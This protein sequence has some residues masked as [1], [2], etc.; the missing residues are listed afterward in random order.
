MSCPY[1]PMFHTGKT[2][3]NVFPFEQYL[4]IIIIIEKSSCQYLLTLS[5]CGGLQHMAN[6]SGETYDK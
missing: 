3:H 1:L 6:H 2:E 5:D 4:N